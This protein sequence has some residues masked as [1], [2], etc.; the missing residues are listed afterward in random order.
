MMY[1][2]LDMEHK[3][4]NFLSF[5]NIFCPFTPLWTQKIKIF[6]KNEKKNT[7]PE[8]IVILKT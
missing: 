6:K 3:R 5:R 2:S 8:D 1:R 7:T 4:H